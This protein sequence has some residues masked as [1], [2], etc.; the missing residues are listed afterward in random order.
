LEDPRRQ[1]AV[2]GSMLDP[3]DTFSERHIGPREDEIQ[4]MLDEGVAKTLYYC[5]PEEMEPGL[6]YCLR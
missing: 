4:Q 5:A 2:S 1:G 3:S 6:P